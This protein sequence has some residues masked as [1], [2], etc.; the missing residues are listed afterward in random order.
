MSFVYS[1]VGVQSRVSHDAINEI[2]DDAGD[3][4]NSAEA[5]RRAMAALLVLT[6][7]NYVIVSWRFTKCNVQQSRPRLREWAG[8][9]FKELQPRRSKLFIEQRRVRT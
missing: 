6:S 2:V 3:A 8:V 9:R 7:G 4:V 1:W 5:I